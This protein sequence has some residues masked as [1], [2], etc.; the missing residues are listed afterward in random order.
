[1][2]ADS[3]RVAGRPAHDPSGRG[4][5][6]LPQVPTVVDAQEQEAA[7]GAENQKAGIDG[8]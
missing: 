7:A 3:L 1:M 6:A 8:S 5:A 4:R 2:R